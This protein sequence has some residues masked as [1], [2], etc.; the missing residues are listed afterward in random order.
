MQSS[1][2]RKSL[3]NPGFNYEAHDLGHIAIQVKNLS[4]PA[5]RITVHVGRTT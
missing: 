4:A 2:V 5:E 3:P 1:N